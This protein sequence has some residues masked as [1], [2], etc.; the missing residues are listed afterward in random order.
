M[1]RCLSMLPLK[2]YTRKKIFNY[3]TGLSFFI[4]IW[5]SK[6]TTDEVRLVRHEKIH[7]RQ[8][9]ELLFV[10]HWML[11]IIFYLIS[12]LK[13]Y[14]HYGAY[15]CN[16]FELEAFT[17]DIDTAYLQRR[18]PYAWLNYIW[19]YYRTLRQHK[20]QVLENS[21]VVHGTHFDIQT[22]DLSEQQSSNIFKE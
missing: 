17:N 13:G 22:T 18:K 12:R 8:Q 20:A 21:L 15:R 7:F 3:Y 11:Y 6:L 4:F 10:F 2:I 5:I 9:I 16:P 19:E 1:L 14:G